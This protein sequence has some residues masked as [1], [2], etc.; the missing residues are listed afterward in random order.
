M[1]VT[2]APA[3]GEEAGASRRATVR[4]G[5]SVV[6]GDPLREAGRSSPSRAPG[7]RASLAGWQ[8]TPRAMAASTAVVARRGIAIINH[9]SSTTGHDLRKG[10]LTLHVGRPGGVR[11][12]RVRCL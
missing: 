3:A 11:E 2:T 1:T 8:D 6:H 9:A 4:P 5:A 12:A 7:P 10:H